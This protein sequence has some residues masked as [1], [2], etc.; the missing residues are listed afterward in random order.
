MH[1]LA[2]HQSDY[3]KQQR[4]MQAQLVTEINTKF[5]V[6]ARDMQVFR[7]RLRRTVQQTTRHTLAEQLDVSSDLPRA[8][9]LGEDLDILA[10]RTKR[11]EVRPIKY[12]ASLG[13]LFIH[14]LIF[15]D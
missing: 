7:L 13:T 5:S 6:L 8:Q 15:C 4:I 10:T 1:R 9:Q 12:S 2:S 3:M 14:Q 11:L